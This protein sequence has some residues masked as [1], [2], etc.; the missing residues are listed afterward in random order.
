MLKNIP[1][2]KMGHFY[3]LCRLRLNLSTSTLFP[4]FLRISLVEPGPVGTAFVSN[5][6]RVDTSTA[7]QKSLQLLQAFV[8]F[9]SCNL[10]VSSVSQKPEEIA[11]VIKEVL[12]SA[13]PHFRY[14]TNKKVS[15]AKINAKLV[16]PTGDKLQEVIDKQDFFGMKSEWKKKM[17]SVFYRLITKHG[18]ENF[19]FEP[20]ALNWLTPLVIKN[21]IVMS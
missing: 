3:P 8:S 16:D 6:S 12:L 5:L 9:V 20:E 21:D 1:Q 17:T 14:I 10:T 15:V 4:F 11:E 18:N 2:S 7:D 19:D 13:K